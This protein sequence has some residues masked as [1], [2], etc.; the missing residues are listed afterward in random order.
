MIKVKFG[1][2][3]MEGSAAV[4]CAEATTMLYVIRKSLTENFGEQEMEI[5]FNDIIEY[6]KNYPD[7]SKNTLSFVQKELLDFLK[8][9]RRNKDE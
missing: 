1:K 9:V 4:I 8:S 7:G 2:V 3:E 5:M 6:S